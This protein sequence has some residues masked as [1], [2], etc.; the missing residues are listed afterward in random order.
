MQESSDFWDG[1]SATVFFY[2]KFPVAMELGSI[3]TTNNC[4]T[5]ST[6]T[7]SSSSS[8][9]VRNLGFLSFFVGN[10][11][12][13]KSG[14][15]QIGIRCSSCCRIESSTRL[16]GFLSLMG[17]DYVRRKGNSSSSS[18]NCLAGEECLSNSSSELDT[19]ELIRRGD[20]GEHP[21][22]EALAEVAK[23]GLS[24]QLMTT[25]AEIRDRRVGGSNVITFSPKVFIPLTRVCRDFCGYC[26]FALGPKPGQPIFMS[27]A[28]VHFQPPREQQ[29]TE[30]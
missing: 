8:L 29:N 20:L 11:Q 23:L 28:E 5:R 14:T 30:R 12:Q 1:I 17:C 2:N 18:R 16:P 13:L 26:T 19:L 4:V 24:P 10:W 6:I 3:C 27:I 9:Q 21:D 25:A 15:A 22:E 7:S